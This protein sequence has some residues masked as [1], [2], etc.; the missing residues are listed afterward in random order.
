LRLAFILQT[1]KNLGQIAQLVRA[2]ATGSGP[3][4]IVISHHGTDS[5]RAFLAQLPNVSQVFAAPGGRGSFGLLDGL[6]ECL[7]WLEAQPEGYDWVITL[8][9]QDYPIRRI[10]ELEHVL[11]SDPHDGIFYHFAVDAQPPGHF[12]H[13]WWPLEEARSRYFFKYRRLK[14]SASLLERALL[15]IPR[16]LAALTNQVRLDTSYGLNIGWR[17]EAHPFT[18]DFK[19]FGGSLWVVLRRRAVQELLRFIAE[20]PAVVDYFRQVLVPDES[21]IPTVLGNCRSLTLSSAELHYYDFRGARHGHP[22]I[23]DEGDLDRA[24][25]L[26]CHFVRKVD[27]TITPGLLDRIDEKFLGLAA[28][29]T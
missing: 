9:G 14:N 21:L 11:A 15:K 8:S 1:H 23:I 19:L 13:F 3:H 25:G 22:K 28:S 18:N 16:K 2:L 29:K 5:E 24:L 27:A 26:G 6:L 4:S 10:S 7:Q 17:A 20:E 12:S